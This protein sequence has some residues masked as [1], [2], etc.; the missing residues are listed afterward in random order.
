MAEIEQLSIGIEAEAPKAA[1]TIDSLVG[2][3]DILVKCLSAVATTP[4]KINID[5]SKFDKIGK[6]LKLDGLGKAAKVIG[7]STAQ[8]TDRIEEFRKKYENIGKS[9]EASDSLKKAQSQL[10][11][12]SDLFQ[13]AKLNKE[14]FEVS[15]NLDTKGYERAV[16]NFYKYSNVIENIK[17]KITELNHTPIKFDFSQMSEAE[18]DKALGF[19][20]IHTW[21]NQVSEASETLL[22]ETKETAREFTGI[23][24]GIAL[25]DLGSSIKASWKSRQ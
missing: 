6:P 12:F 23:W 11:Q 20:N 7:A 24:S 8:I 4:V 17:Q 13:K 22:Q 21:N 9:F 1:K 15:G 3:L 10:L 2:K 25:P 16:E 14:S 5:T 19:P 18:L